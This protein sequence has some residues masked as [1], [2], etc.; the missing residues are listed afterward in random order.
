MVPSEPLHPL[1]LTTLGVGA[2]VG[3]DLDAVVDQITPLAAE[4]SSR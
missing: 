1:A 2:D 4:S 3:T